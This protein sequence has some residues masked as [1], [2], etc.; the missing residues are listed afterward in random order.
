[1][2]E[3]IGENKRNTIILVA[4][5]SIFIIVLAWL[6]GRIVFGI[7]S[8]GLAIG[9]IFVIVYSLVNYFYSDRIVLAISGAREVKKDEHPYLFNVI[10][11]LSVAAGISKPKAYVI[12]DTALNAFATGRDPEHGIVVVTTGILQ[13]LDRQELEGVI[14]HEMSHIKNYDIRLST[15]VSVLVGVT[16]L[17]SDVL[18]RA[19]LWGHRD[20]EQGRMGLVLLLAGVALAVL[21]PFIAAIINMAISRQREYL[22]DA[23]AALLTRNPNGLASALAKIG[24]DKEVLEA[25]NKA[26][27]HMY[28]DNPL[29]NRRSF[30]DGMFS[31]HPP[32]ADRIARLRNM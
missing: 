30:F 1:M 23:S 3:Q 22:A 15:I 24:G 17:L 21:T 11:G 20:R 27:A 18:L 10:D 31:T 6:L 26:T 5:F 8:F 14:A 25:A 2:Y 28:I 16:A 32:I 12:N 29:K 19:T 7:G 4:A 9:G 13:K